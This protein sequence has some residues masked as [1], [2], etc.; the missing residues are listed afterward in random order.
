[1]VLGLVFNRLPATL[2]LATVA[3]LMAIAIGATA[4]ILGARSRGTAVEAGI[5]VASGA[6]LSIPDFLWGLVL[7]L[8]FVVLVPV[9]DISG[10]VSPELDLPFVTQFYLVESILRLRFDLTWDLLK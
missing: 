4:A 5:D 2:E 8:L 7:I 6:T 1:D 10:R 3:L 9:F